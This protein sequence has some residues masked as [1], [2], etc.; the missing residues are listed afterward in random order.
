VTARVECYSGYKADEEPRR[1]TLLP[2]GSLSSDSAARTY[3]VQEVVDQWYGEGY[4]CFR[5]RADDGH[6]YVLRRHLG[7]DRWTLDAFR[8]RS[9]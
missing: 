4:Q 7:Q 3:E 5:V 9:A 2:E 8:S 1:F 6:L